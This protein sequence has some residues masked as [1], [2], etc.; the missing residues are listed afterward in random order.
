M[1]SGASARPV[2]ENMA[3][4]ET[5]ATTEH[6]VGT[7]E[8]WLSARRERLERVKELAYP[9]ESNFL[10]FW[11]QVLARAPKVRSD[12]VPVRSNDEYDA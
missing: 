5:N 1:S 9:P 2:V 3:L 12:D 7:R 8:E 10:V 11:A 4:E 6:E